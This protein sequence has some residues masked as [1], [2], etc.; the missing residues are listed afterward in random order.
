V[1]GEGDLAEPVPVLASVVSAEQQL[2]A[3]RQLNSYV[4]LCSAAVAAVRCSEGSTRRD[5]SRHAYLFHRGEADKIAL[6]RF[7]IKSRR[8]L[9]EAFASRCDLFRPRLWFVT[10]TAVD[11]SPCSLKSD[12]RTGS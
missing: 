4:C 2:T 5:C 11:G 10:T 7:N 6:I 1:D 9:P 8:T 3:A 12:S